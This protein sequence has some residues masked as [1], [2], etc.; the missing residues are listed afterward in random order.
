MY[1]KTLNETLCILLCLFILYCNNFCL[2]KE[3][4]NIFKKRK[5]L[6]YIILFSL[7][8]STCKVLFIIVFND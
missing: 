2:S 4:E 6:K 3:K 5:S 1:N 7:T 8:F